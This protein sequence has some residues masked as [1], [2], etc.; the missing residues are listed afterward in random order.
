MGEV[1]PSKC[2]MLC[3]NS[4]LVGLSD[5]ARLCTLEE[6]GVAF[7]YGN[8][9]ILSP[10]TYRRKSGIMLGLGIIDMVS[11]IN[12]NKNYGNTRSGG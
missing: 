5:V 3:G 6:V 8:C 9:N 12:C 4:F 1:F 2:L 11:G 7:K 10:T